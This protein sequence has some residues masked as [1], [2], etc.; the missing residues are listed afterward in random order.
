MLQGIEFLAVLASAGFGILLARSKHMDFVG[1]YTV[2]LATAFGG[3]TLRDLFLDR[4]PLFWIDKPYYALM[5]FALAILGMIAGKIVDDAEFRRFLHIPDAL[6]IGLFSIVGAGFAMEANTGFFIAS[7]F[8]VITGCFGGVIADI[9][10]NEV[11][12]LFR[13]TPLCA[14][15]AFVGSWVYLLLTTIPD[16]P[17]T[18]SATVA[19]SV[20]VAMRLL[21]VRYGWTLPLSTPAPTAKSRAPARK[22]SSAKKKTAR[23]R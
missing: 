22:K 8:G 1:V 4:H 19:I 20:I 13:K 5:V 2:A 3:G 7:L 6:G 9:I 14:T 11:P 16:V 21:A 17:E 15:C 10:C 18:L 12:S 23:K